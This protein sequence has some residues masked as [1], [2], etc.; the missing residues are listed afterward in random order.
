MIF[1]LDNEQIS[2]INAL[3]IS[4]NTIYLDKSIALDFLACII[5]NK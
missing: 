2:N 5:I 4:N 3:L 1:N